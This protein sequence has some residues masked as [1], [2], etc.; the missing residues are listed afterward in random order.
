MRSVLL[1]C[2]TVSLF[3]SCS[4]DPAST[5]GVQ[6]TTQ[7]CVCSDG[8]AGAQ[9][10]GADGLWQA[11]SCAPSSDTVGGD[12]S[13]PDTN[14]PDT[15]TPDTSAP[16]VAPVR[17]CTDD[18]ADNYDAAANT[19]D[20]SCRYVVTFTVD[21]SALGLSDSDVV[22]VSGDFGDLVGERDWCI[23]CMPMTTPGARV[24]TTSFVL[25]RGTYQ[26]A[27]HVNDR[28][29][30]ELV[31]EACGVTNGGFVNRPLQVTDAPVE[32]PVVN[33]GSCPCT[34]ENCSGMNTC[35]A[36][37]C[38]SRF[39]GRYTP[40]RFVIETERGT[41]QNKMGI[42]IGPDNSLRIYGVDPT[43]GEPDFSFSEVSCESSFSGSS[44]KMRVE[45]RGD[46]ATTTTPPNT[47]S[48]PFKLVFSH[49]NVTDE[50]SGTLTGSITNETFTGTLGGLPQTV[51]IGLDNEVRRATF[52]SPSE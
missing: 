45:V 48:R 31:P 4:D 15:N 38:V 8:S 22:Y 28:S 26:Y 35:T 49:A 40:G 52:T 1:L 9:T 21:A 5:C 18:D 17:G 6:G 33:F 2:G 41:C 3:M 39:E 12:T 32:L 30:R 23:D 25:P 46:G 51:S 16:D 13:Q 37:R 43:T 50:V 19:D 24:Y 36:G 10:C 11:C 29:P 44:L 27:F 47:F 7:A 34:P 14:T 20:G 42:S